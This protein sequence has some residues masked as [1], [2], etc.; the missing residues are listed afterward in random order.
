MRSS[1]LQAKIAAME[2]EARTAFLRRMDEL[3][4][5]IEDLDE[6]GYPHTR[7][8]ISAGEVEGDLRP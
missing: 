4:A 3:F 6:A 1:E 2:P 5:E 8:R 7:D